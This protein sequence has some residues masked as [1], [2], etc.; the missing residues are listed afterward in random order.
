LYVQYGEVSYQE[1]PYGIIGEALL[2]RFWYIEY[3]NC[4]SI[5]ELGHSS[6]G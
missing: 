1:F 5:G 6:G 4:G 3:L 2:D